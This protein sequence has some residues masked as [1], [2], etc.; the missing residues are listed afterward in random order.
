MSENV[1]TPT[2]QM[3]PGT[4][5]GIKL[6]PSHDASL[7]LSTG[8]PSS[9]T[10]PNQHYSNQHNGYGHHHNHHTAYP[11]AATA[12]DFFFEEILLVTIL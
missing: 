9:N 4:G 6:S 3:H 5:P 10:Q 12:R 11:G 1:S 2:G 8:V 7:S